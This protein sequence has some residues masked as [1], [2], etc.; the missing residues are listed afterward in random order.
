MERNETEQ[1]LAQIMKKRS[2]IDF[3]KEKL[4]QDEKL[5]GHKIRMTARELLYAYLDIENA[6]EI[7][8]PE[9]AITDGN[10]DTFS[11]MLHIV[12]EQLPQ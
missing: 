4:L 11:N 6:F 9:I 10:F 2:G 5:L 8:I 3:M 12:T 1:I 7:K